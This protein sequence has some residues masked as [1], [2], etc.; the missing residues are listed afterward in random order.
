MFDRGGGRFDPSGQPWDD[1]F[2]S[3]GPSNT[4][5][6]KTSKIAILIGSVTGMLT[7][8]SLV[9]RWMGN[10]LFGAFGIYIDIWRG[11]YT[12]PNTIPDRSLNE[13]LEYV[14]LPILIAAVLA[15]LAGWLATKVSNWL[16]D[17]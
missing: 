13:I 6:H 10:W 16:L 15:V 7:F 4:Y 3:S 5:Q 17:K 1:P 9:H 14:S 2:D 12:F 11:I 8:V